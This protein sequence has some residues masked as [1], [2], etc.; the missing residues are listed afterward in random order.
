LNKNKYTPEYDF[1]KDQYKDLIDRLRSLGDLELSP[2]EKEKILIEVK[3]AKFTQPYELKNNIPKK[4]FI[5]TYR[6]YFGFVTLLLLV[7]G[8]LFFFQSIPQKHDQLKGII[9]KDSSTTKPD[10]LNSK[11][12]VQTEKP[13]VKENYWK[14]LFDEV[15]KNYDYRSLTLEENNI[16]KIV[17]SEEFRKRMGVNSTRKDTVDLVIKLIKLG[18]F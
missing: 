4:S 5:Y 14:A 16:K 17:K 9:A 3:K 15:Q 7:I 10:T 1:E 6:Y 2:E 11:R 8:Y 18:I 12:F 13:P